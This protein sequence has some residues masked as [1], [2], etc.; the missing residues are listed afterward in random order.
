MSYEEKANKNVIS[1]V[2]FVNSEKDSKISGT[3]KD[4]K[5]NKTNSNS[6]INKNNPNNN[7]FNN[8]NAN[9]NSNFIK[10]NNKLEELKNI[11]ENNTKNNR[12]KEVLNK[13]LEKNILQDNRM[14][15]PRFG[16]MK[17]FSIREGRLLGIDNV[18]RKSK[19]KSIKNK[20]SSKIKSKQSNNTNT[21]STSPNISP[22]TLLT[23]ISNSAYSPYRHTNKDNAYKHSTSKVIGKDANENKANVVYLSRRQKKFMGAFDFVI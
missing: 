12:I 7:N 9:N 18:I 10:N 11:S 3:E 17:R 16:V 6:N 13:P 14:K 4:S 5:S 2:R 23:S 1:N 21:Q 22:T 8:D 15:M 20:S 19:E